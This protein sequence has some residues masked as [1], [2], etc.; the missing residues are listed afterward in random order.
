MCSVPGVGG[1]PH[2]GP[3][4]SML[5]IHRIGRLTFALLAGFA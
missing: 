2:L 4:M 5:L 1:K 3:F